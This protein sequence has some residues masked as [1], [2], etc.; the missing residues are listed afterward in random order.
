[1]NNW[2]SNAARKVAK[3]A[4]S[5]KGQGAQ[6]V[7]ASGI[8]PSG[9]I[10]L[11]NLREV[12]TV[13]LVHQELLRQGYDAVH[14]HF[15]DDFDRFRKV[16]ANVSPEFEKHIGKPLSEVPHPFGGEGSYA[17]HFIAEFQGCLDQMGVKP[18]SIRQSEIYAGDA[19]LDSV[20]KALEHRNEIFE[21]LVKHQSPEKQIES[22]KNQ[23]N[24]YPFSVYSSVSGNDNTQILDYNASTKALTYKC[25]DS[26]Q[27][28]KAPLEDMLPGK[29]VWKVDWPMRWQKYQVDF[30]PGGVDHSTPG[31]SYTVGK[32]IVKDIYGG[33]PPFYI[34]YSFVSI[35]GNS[36][37]ISSSSGTLATPSNALKVLE[38]AILRWLY[39]R[40]DA[41][42]SFK[43]S[44]DDQIMRLYDEWDR[45]VKK[46]DEGKAKEA[47]AFIFEHSTKTTKEAIQYSTNPIPFRVLA[48]AYEITKEDRAGFTR[49]VLETVGEQELDGDIRIDLAKGWVDEFLPEEDKVLIRDQFDADG[50]A[51]LS[52]QVKE[53]LKTLCSRL[54]AELD[55]KQVQSELYAVPKHILGLP[56]DA[57]PS[58]ELKL[59]QREFYQ[60]LYLLLINREKGPRLPTLFN[61]IGL[62]K[63]LLLLGES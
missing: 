51:G 16:P 53:A 1:M 9:S 11:G 20:I 2:I 10:H 59:F 41:R 48:S 43:I 19:Y 21:I 47:E 23:D 56:R 39:V 17:D 28:I 45:L 24:Y 15:W 7:C 55:L 8:S 50:F 61:A 14:L 3:F 5:N 46:N 34:G 18:D 42:K 6:I 57:K 62:E 25:L 29:L 31:S 38:P 26:D 22:R 37:K 54:D 63:L 12:M 13:H 60:S 35:S 44:F 49:I 58:P 33:I 40:T 30:E 32:E 4:E 27:T 52:D 36:T